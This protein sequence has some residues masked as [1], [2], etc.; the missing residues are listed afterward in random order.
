MSNHNLRFHFKILERKKMASYTHPALSYIF[1]NLKQ[2]YRCVA[3][4]RGGWARKEWS[5]T[6]NSRIL[7]TR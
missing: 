7:E 5:T 6:V 3:V 1:R 4:R 2:N